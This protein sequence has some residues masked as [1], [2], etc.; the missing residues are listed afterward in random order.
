MFITGLG[1]AVP[2]RRYMQK[3]GW[4]FI[5]A[6]SRFHQLSSRSQAIL[7]KVLLG[8][9]GIQS[10]HL[11]LNSLDEVLHDN[12]DT[13]HQRFL[14]NAPLLAAQAANRAL[15]DAG[16]TAHEIDAVIVST[17][18]GYLCPGLTSYVSERLGLTP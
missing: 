2:A 3:E 15:I 11:C 9:N 13:L 17:C 1:T 12:V 16:V 5:C 14:R 8:D 18:T 10:R 7:H 4:D 6:Q